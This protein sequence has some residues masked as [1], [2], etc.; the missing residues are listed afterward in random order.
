MFTNITKT[1]NSFGIFWREPVAKQEENAVLIPVQQIRPQYGGI[2]NFAGPSTYQTNS[3][4][5]K[6]DIL[7]RKSFFTHFDVISNPR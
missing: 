1:R 5:Q 2:S 6:V 7:F 4:K 3:V